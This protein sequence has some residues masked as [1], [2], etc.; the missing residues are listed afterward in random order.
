MKNKEKEEEKFFLNNQIKNAEN[1]YERG[2]KDYTQNFFKHLK[3]R[4]YKNQVGYVSVDR[5]QAEK[6][7]VID[8]W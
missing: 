7:E 2:V 4:D 1:L 8:K 6:Q 5:R 3:D